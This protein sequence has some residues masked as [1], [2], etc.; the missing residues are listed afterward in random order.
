MPRIEDIGTFHAVREIGLA[1]LLPSIPRITI[2]MGTCGRG[3]GAEG[4]YHAFTEAIDR[5][6]VNVL[7]AGVGCFGACYQEPLV[8][9]RV[10]GAPL[11]ILRQV[12]SNDVGRILHDLALGTVPP[13][14][15]FCKIE[16]WDHITGF[17]RYG[18]GFPE[19][20]SSSE[21]PFFKGQKKIVLRNC[22]LINPDDI[23]EYIAVGYCAS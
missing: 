17:I 3:N 8:S 20:P 10:P 9:I 13:D 12:Q 4:L 18:R 7:L 14:L 2:G 6:G 5:S 21:V 22:G 16:E 1:K 15:I 23:E 11:L 19:V